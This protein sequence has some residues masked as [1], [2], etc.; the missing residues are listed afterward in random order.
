MNAKSLDV[1]NYYSQF[2]GVGWDLGLMHSAL[3]KLDIPSDIKESLE[4]IPSAT[5]LVLGSATERNIDQMAHIDQALRPGLSYDDNVLMIDYN[6][7]P[8]QRHQQRWEWLEGMARTDEQSDYLPYPEYM[9]VQAD[10]KQLPISDDLIDVAVSDYTLNFFDDYS[11]VQ[12][13]LAEVARVL[14]PGGI[15]LL[16]AAGH[17]QID[18]TIPLE[19]LTI[20]NA[21]LKQR[22]GG[23]TTSQFP[24]QFYEKAAQDSGFDIRV[25]ASTS[26]DLVCSILQKP[27]LS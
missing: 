3:S 6:H 11:D 23:S 9:F 8:M 10:M 12:A 27:F 2:E 21:Q 13:A 15:L 25:N 14:K 24:R 18:P 1:A 16:S 26:K 5:L 4:S 19:H 7:Y 22:I 17:E 20:R